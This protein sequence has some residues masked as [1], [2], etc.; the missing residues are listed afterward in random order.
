MLSARRVEP[1][2][3]G[4]IEVKVYTTGLSGHVSKNIVVVS[5]DPQNR[6][7]TLQVRAEVLPEFAF[8]ALGIFFSGEPRGRE[9]RREL[10]IEVAPGRPSSIVSVESTDPQVKVRL[11]QVP[12]SGERKYRLIATQRADAPEGYHF[13]TIIIKT[14]SKLNPEIRLPIR[15]LVGP[16]GGQ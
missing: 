14:T 8:S 4:R 12:G 6:E 13:G 16:S 9:A 2:G 1:G 5:N 15:G 11:E 3:T 7:V 10:T